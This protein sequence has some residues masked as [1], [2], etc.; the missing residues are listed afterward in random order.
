MIRWSAT[1]ILLTLLAHSD[2]LLLLTPLLSHAGQAAGRKWVI[3][4]G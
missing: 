3:L 1:D 4:V 2:H